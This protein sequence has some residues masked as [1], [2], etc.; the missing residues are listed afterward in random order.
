MIPREGCP[1]CATTPEIIE[2]G[3][4]RSN[5]VCQ[6]TGDGA[7]STEDRTQRKASKLK[8]TISFDKRRDG[9]IGIS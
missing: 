1:K 8:G 6:F 7:H 5:A 4:D 3:R 9:V 2:Q